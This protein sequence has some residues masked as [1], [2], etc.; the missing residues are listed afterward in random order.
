MKASVRATIRQYNHSLPGIPRS[1]PKG[2]PMPA[3]Q[4]PSGTG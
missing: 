2:A 1:A 4:S 3:P